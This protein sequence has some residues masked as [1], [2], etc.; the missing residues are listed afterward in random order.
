MN[1]RL[2]SHGELHPCL[3]AEFGYLINYSFNSLD[4]HVLIGTRT[5][6]DRVEPTE[7]AETTGSLAEAHRAAC[8]KFGLHDPGTATLIGAELLAHIPYSVQQQ[9]RSL[10][11]ISSATWYFLYRA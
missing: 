2:T 6:A 3:R 8:D 9:Q 10:I 1:K 7:V 11:S 4:A 5:R